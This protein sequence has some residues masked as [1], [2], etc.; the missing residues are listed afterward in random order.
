MKYGEI[1]EVDA[2]GDGTVPEPSSHPSEWEDE[3]YEKLAR[4]FSQSHA[5]LQSTDSLLT[6]VSELLKG[7]VGKFMGGTGIGLEVPAIVEAGKTIPVDVVSQDGN[8]T[9][10]LHAICEGEDG[11]PR[12]NPKLMKALREGH[13]QAKFD[14]LPE[15]AFKITVRSATPAKPIDPVSDWTLV[16]NAEAN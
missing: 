12:G 10:A 5:V 14:G 1:K 4:P 9:L 16:W 3:Q 13:Y 8:S 15:G 2:A 7:N 11:Q 6:Q